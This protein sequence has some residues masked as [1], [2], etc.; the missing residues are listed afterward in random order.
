M[1]R[2]QQIG[3]LL[4]RAAHPTRRPSVFEV[5]CQDHTAGSTKHQLAVFQV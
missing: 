4:A 5:L 2:L 1:S 3:E